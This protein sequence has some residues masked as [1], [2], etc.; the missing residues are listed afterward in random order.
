MSNVKTRKKNIY[1]VQL[2][3]IQQKLKRDSLLLS[4]HVTLVLKEHFIN[5]QGTI[6]SR[7]GLLGPMTV[8]GEILLYG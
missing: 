8:F 1:T 2:F 4:I 7:E 5:K 6:V 3:Y